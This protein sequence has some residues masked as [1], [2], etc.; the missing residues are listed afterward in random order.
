MEYPS[1]NGTMDEYNKKR[2]ESRNFCPSIAGFEP[3]AP[4]KVAG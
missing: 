1:I 3:L 4:Q 2:D